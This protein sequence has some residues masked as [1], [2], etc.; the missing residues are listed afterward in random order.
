LAKVGVAFFAAKEL[1][2]VLVLDILRPI[3]HESNFLPR[4]DRILSQFHMPAYFF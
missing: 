1:H 4:T 3:S 2:R